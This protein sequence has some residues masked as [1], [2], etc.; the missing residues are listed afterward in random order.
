M[1]DSFDELRRL[2][3][4]PEFVSRLHHRDNDAWTLLRAILRCTGPR[5]TRFLRNETNGIVDEDDIISETLL[6]LWGYTSREPPPFPKDASFF[7]FVRAV[8]NRIVY[9]ILRHYAVA[10]RRPKRASHLPDEKRIDVHEVPNRDPQ[11]EAIDRLIAKEEIN[12]LYR[13]VSSLELGEQNLVISLLEG[14]TLQETA[15]SF[16]QG[17]RV[18]IQ[19]AA[20]Q[21]KRLLDKLRRCLTDQGFV[22]SSVQS[23]AAEVLLDALELRRRAAMDDL[24]LRLSTFTD[25][26]RPPPKPEQREAPPKQSESIDCTAFA[27]SSIEADATF[28]LQVFVH[29]RSRLGEAISQAREFEHSTSRRGQTALTQ[30][31]GYGD[32]LTFDLA[33]RGAQCDELRKSLV[34]RG[35]TANVAFL[36]SGPGERRRISGRVGISTG[37][38]PIGHIVFVIEVADESR[39]LR[40]EVQGRAEFYDSFFIS[41]ASKDRPEV[42]KRVQMLPRLGKRFRQD[43]LDIDPGDRWERKLYAFIEECDATLLFWSESA[44]QSEWVIKE[45]EYCIEKKG[46]ER[47]LPVIIERPPPL[48]PAQLAEMHMN[49]KL[50]YFIE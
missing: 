46:I 13:A 41:Y 20:N 45:C 25:A 22:S 48:P 8:H 19:S 50:L 29:L 26:T 27:P 23:P 37:T 38:V 47:L 39:N 17:K 30:R 49:D 36:V 42:I 16:G 34:W 6:N 5:P 14:K 43:L 12:R 9:G 15:A 24:Q 28:L 18:P 11:P 7:A 33:L 35:E 32:V 2:V 4:A 10:K 31:L 1:I 40:P 3:D 44:K 21:R